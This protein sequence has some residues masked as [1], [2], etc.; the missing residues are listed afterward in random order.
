MTDKIALCA[1]HI[2]LPTT[3]ITA[4]SPEHGPETIECARDEVLASAGLLDVIRECE[5][6]TNKPDAYIVAC[7]G[8]PALMPLRNSPK[9]QCLV[10]HKLPFMPPV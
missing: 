7:F 4:C 5:Q 1:K 8:D 9:L 2:A 6:E 3:Q 10:L